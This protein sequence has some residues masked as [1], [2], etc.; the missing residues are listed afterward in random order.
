MNSSSI[1]LKKVFAEFPEAFINSSNELILYPKTNLYF[2][3]DDINTELDLKRKVIEWCS[4]AAHKAMPYQSDSDNRKYNLMILNRINNI[5]DSK[6][7]V[8]DIETIYTKLGN[9]VNSK[10]CEKFILSGYDMNI[11]EDKTNE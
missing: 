4:R 2:L 6:F 8:K 7:G 5:L 3:L 10:L 9:A 1:E 11:L